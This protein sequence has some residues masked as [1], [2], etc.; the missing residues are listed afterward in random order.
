MI[1]ITSDPRYFVGQPYVHGWV[2]LMALNVNDMD[3]GQTWFDQALA[4][5]GR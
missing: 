2:D 4:P 1:P 5:K 3:W